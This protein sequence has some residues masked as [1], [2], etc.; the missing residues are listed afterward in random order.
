MLVVADNGPGIPEEELPY[1]FDAFYR[2][3]HSRQ[4]AG[5]GLGLTIVKSIVDLHGWEIEA[6]NRT[7]DGA[8]I[9][10]AAGSA[11]SHGLL[12]AIRMKAAL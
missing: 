11:A 4:E 12:I 8:A 7:V 9:G 6:H 2:G 1:V 5:H 3:T 10:V